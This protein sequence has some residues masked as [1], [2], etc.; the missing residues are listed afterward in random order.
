MKTIKITL[1]LIAVLIVITSCGGTKKEKADEATKQA[2]AEV[3]KIV[4]MASVEPLTRIVSLYSD[5]GG[6]VDKINYDINSE[7]KVND[8]IFVLNTQVEEAQLA[9]AKS[10]LGTQQAMINV[11]KAQLASLKVK[12]DNAQVN[13]NR[14]ANLVKAGAVTQQVTDDSKFA[15]ESLQNDV[16]ASDAGLKQQDAKVSELQADINYYERVIDKKKI[17]APANGKILSVDVR[18]GNN[19][20]ASQSV[21]DFAPDGPLIAITEVDELFATKIAVGMKAYIRPQG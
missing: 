6:I 21:G 19:V 14:N 10:K 13:Y 17:K 3:S 20:L 15:F 16:L 7:V 9:Q 18:L 1:R 2:P 5:V 4:G 11:A 12:Q 8:V